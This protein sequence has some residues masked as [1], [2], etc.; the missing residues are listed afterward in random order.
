[1]S[2]L[3]GSYPN[4]PIA[5]YCYFPRKLPTRFR[6]PPLRTASITFFGGNRRVMILTQCKNQN[7]ERIVYK[8]SLHCCLLLMSERR[9]CAYAACVAAC[10]Y[11]CAVLTDTR[12]IARHNFLLCQNAW[13]RYCGVSCHDGPSGIWAYKAIGETNNRRLAASSFTVVFT[14]LLSFAQ[15]SLGMGRNCHFD[16]K[17]VAVSV[18]ASLYSALSLWLVAVSRHLSSWGFWSSECINKDV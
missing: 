16:N 5:H 1:M 17:I 7:N 4:M 9:T 11:A 2:C 15:P 8:K 14:T 13:A 10:T 6:L 18:T 3:S 12:D